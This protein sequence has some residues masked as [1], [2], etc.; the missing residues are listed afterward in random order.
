MLLLIFT[1]FML[2]PDNP[3]AIVVP[4]TPVPVLKLFLVIFIMLLVRLPPIDIPETLLL[5]TF[6]TLT[7]PLPKDNE[8]LPA[9]NVDNILL[10]L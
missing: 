8:S 10:L 7:L 3:I 2:F 4:A 1:L 5:V 9:A 6:I